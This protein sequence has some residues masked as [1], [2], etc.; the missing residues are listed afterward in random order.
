[1]SREAMFWI[2]LASTAAIVIVPIRCAALLKNSAEPHIEALQWGDTR[3][4]L[5]F[6]SP[7]E[8]LKGLFASVA[9]T[10]HKELMIGAALAESPVNLTPTPPTNN[11]PSQASRLC[12]TNRLLRLSPNDYQSLLEIPVSAVETFA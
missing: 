11:P 9:V 10:H 7:E 5:P 6:T 2:W 4:R 8:N 1:M 12:R 3:V